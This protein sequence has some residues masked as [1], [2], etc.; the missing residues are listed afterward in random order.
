MLVA[1]V[2]CYVAASVDGSIAV[3]E[4]GAKAGLANPIASVSQ[5]DP[6]FLIVPGDRNPTVPIVS[7]G[8]TIPTDRPA[9]TATEW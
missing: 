4:N 1:E 7:R 2:V 6:V 8:P 9:V 3:V 5:D